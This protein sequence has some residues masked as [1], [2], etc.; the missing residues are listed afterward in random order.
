MMFHI[1]TFRW[2]EIGNHGHKIRLHDIFEYAPMRAQVVPREEE[3]R[4][5]LQRPSM[6]REPELTSADA[7]PR[8][9]G[10]CVPSTE[11]CDG[12]D[13]DC[14]G[15]VDEG[16][17]NAC[18]GC[19]ILTNA[20]DSPCSAGTGDCVSTGV[21]RCQGVDAVSCNAS[22]SNPHTWYSDCDGYEALESNVQSCDSP[23]PSSE[24][25]AYIREQPVAGS[26][27]DCSA[28]S[29]RRYPGAEVPCETGCAVLSR[30]MISEDDLDCSGALELGLCC[31]S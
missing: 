23:R 9:G 27:L 21:Y 1:R 10:T 3:F 20:P 16:V 25:R 31:R 15:Q 13:N 18:G 7:A 6:E 14:D 29:P 17:K 24:C 30:E 2:N 8:G 22:P 26:T 4:P 28:G 11:P 19:A 12:V 5:I